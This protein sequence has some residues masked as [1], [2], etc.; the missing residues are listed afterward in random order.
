MCLYKLSPEISLNIGDLS[1]E[2]IV[3]LRLLKSNIAMLRMAFNKIS[4]RILT[5]P[6]CSN[7]KYISIHF[8]TTAPY[9][10]EE[11]NSD[12]L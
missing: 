10:A 8:K 1:F 6:T 3:Y 2:N 9:K 4:Q 11:I 7:S 5:T 12:I